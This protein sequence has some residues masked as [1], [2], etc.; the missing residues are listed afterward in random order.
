MFGTPDRCVKMLRDVADL[1]IEYVL[2]L[3]S[4][5]DMEHGKII[6]SMDLLAGEVLP[7]LEPAPGPPPAELGDWRAV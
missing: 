7:R 5:G 6:R 2:F 3:V 4:L 1:G